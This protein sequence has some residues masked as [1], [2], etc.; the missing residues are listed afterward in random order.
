MKYTKPPQQPDPVGGRRP[1]Q[2]APDPGASSPATRQR[3]LDAGRRL[4]A[5]KGFDGTSVRA[6]TE[7]AGVNLGA[8]TYHF[9]SKERLY[10]SVLDQVLS[11]MRARAEAL[12]GMRIPPL[13]KVELFVRGMFQHL[14]E[15]PDVPRFMVQ[16]VVLGERPSPPIMEAIQTV[17]LLLIDIIREGQAGGAIREGDPVLLAL[18]TLSQPIYLS[19]MPPVISRVEMRRAGFPQPRVPPEDHAVEFVMRGLTARKEKKG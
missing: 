13:G 6:L 9:E 4:F 11:P 1:P 3:L 18:S 5:E 10:R 12:K 14:R 8:V 16:E 7:A 15:N 17:G 19:I 2:D